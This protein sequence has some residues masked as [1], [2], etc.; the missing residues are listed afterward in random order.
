VKGEPAAA[1]DG[2]A[3]YV[4]R[5]H[6]SLAAFAAVLVSA[7]AAPGLFGEARR[8]LHGAPA[9]A[10]ATA[11]AQ[12]LAALNAA[13]LAKARELAA[14]A[15]ERKLYTGRNALYEIVLTYDTDDAEARRALGYKMVKREWQAPKTKR[16][17]VDE[18]EADVP[19]QFAELRRAALADLAA[20]LDTLFDPLPNT[21]KNQ[22]ARRAELTK[23]VVFDDA[24]ALRERL[25]EVWDEVDS[26]WILVETRDARAARAEFAARVAELRAAL[27]PLEEAPY[28]G[29]TRAMEGIVF[30]C[31]L[32]A[33]GVNA[34]STLDLAETTDLLTTV[35]LVLDVVHTAFP[36][37][38]AVHVPTVLYALEPG[39]RARFFEQHP[40]TP[41]DEL[42][43]RSQ[44]NSS[45][46][47]GR[48]VVSSTT[49]VLRKDVAAFQTA[50]RALTE[51]YGVWID[52][53]WA[54]QGLTS[55]LAA[56]VTG[57]RLSFWDIQNTDQYGTKK[58][59]AKTWME[60]VPP[61]TRGWL[62]EAKALVDEG[63]T[64]AHFSRA[65][66]APTIQMSWEDVVTS[67][68]VAAYLFETR[69]DALATILMRTKKEPAL[70]VFE[71]V[72]AM[73]LDEFRARLVRW[74]DEI[75]PLPTVE[76]EKKKRGGS[77]GKKPKED[78][79][80][81]DEKKG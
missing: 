33:R 43:Y 7:S 57:T 23:L 56:Q 50:A 52:D 72:L 4:A 2:A 49:P 21:P 71:E 11:A 3:R 63:Q 8:E 17:P 29:N 22:A 19:A 1:P 40:L 16:E 59:D 10:F 34:T 15:N 60:R 41:K 65:L 32:A 77:A 70:P 66:A 14:W 53:G 13:A 73:P 28:D 81:G 62:L 5:M 42:A 55:Y 79:A 80:G 44:S 31:A 61:S 18:C 76:D 45:W 12:D 69:R 6:R 64:M 25:G 9:A 27:P 58:S 35:L 30:E 47:D 37:Q 20:Q 39:E 78:P 51:K 54:Q 67:H 75:E 48:L 74:I 24:S 36:S 46:L 68:A 26:K 38:P